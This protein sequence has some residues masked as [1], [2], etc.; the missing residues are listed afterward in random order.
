MLIVGAVAGVLASVLVVV[1]SGGVGA[2]GGVS[3]PSGL[4]AV[5]VEGGVL[6]SWDAPE[7]GASEVSGYRVFRRLPESGERRLSVL[8][9]DTGSSE[10]SFLDVSAVVEGELFV[11]RVAAL[12]D[13]VVGEGS[14]RARVRYEA[15]EPELEPV[16]RAVEPEPEVEADAD[17]VVLSG[18]LSVGSQGGVSPAMSGFSS[19]ARAGS[20]SPRSFTVDGSAVRVL[21]LVEH[22]GG[23]FLATDQAM[24][25]DFVL[26]V[27]GLEFVGSESLVPA[28]PVRGA[29]WWPSGGLS[30]SDGDTVDVEL[31]VAADAVPIG[32]RAAAPLWAYF[33][34]VP[35]THDGTDAFS[36][37]LRFGED[38][39][40]DA[41]ALRDSIVVAAGGTVTAVEPAAGSTRNWTVTI[42]PDGDS[43][44]TISVGG[45]L[46]CADLAAV[47]TA[48]GRTLPAGIEVTV[49]GPSAA[50]SLD[51]L[52][53]DGALLDQAFDPEVT[54]Y[55][56]QADVGISQVTVAGVAR[57]AA[58]SVDILPADADPNAA[59]HQIAVTEGA[60]TAVAVTVTAADRN[61]ERRYWVV[62]DGPPEAGGNDVQEVPGLTGLVLDGL[63][64]FGFTPAQRRYEAVKA[65]GVSMVTV[66][67]SSDDSD[68]TVEVLVVRSDDSPLVIDTNDA[69]PNTAGH[70]VALSEAGETLLLVLV[71]SADAKRQD[72]YLVLVR[73]PALQPPAA[74]GAPVTKNT[75]AP[76]LLRSTPGVALRDTAVP[77]LTALSLDGI[78]LSP[79]FAAA[80]TDYTATVDADTAQVTVTATPAGDA[81]V[82]FTPADADLNSAGWQVALPAAD[83]GG[84]PTQTNIAAIVVSGDTMA[85]NSYLITVT[86]QAPPADDASL[87]SLAL[88]GVA[89]SP[90][91]D[92]ATHSYTAEVGSDVDQVTLDLAA[93]AGATVTVVPADDDPNTA[94][95]QIPLADVQ[96]GGQ[97][98][99]TMVAIIV[100]AADTNTRQTYTVTVTRQAPSAPSPITAVLPE[101]CVLE[102]LNAKDDGTFR[103]SGVWRPECQSIFEYRTNSDDPVAATG[104]ARFYRLDVLGQG[105]VTIEVESDTSRHILLR[106]ADGTLV[107]HTTYLIVPPSDDSCVAL[108]GVSC[109]G[110]PVLNA[111]LPTGSYIVETVQHYR[112]GRQRRS[113][114]TVEGPNIYSV[115]PR[116]AALSVDGTSVA[117]FDYNTFVYELARQSATVTVAAEA[118]AAPPSSAA[119]S[120]LIE[121]ADADAD[122]AGHQVELAEYGLT[123]VTVT[124]TDG[125]G[126]GSNRYVVAF[127]GDHQATTSTSGSI[128]V[129]GSVRARVDSNGDRD[130]FAVDL[131]ADSTYRIDLKGKSS[132]SGSLVDPHMFGVRLADGT[133][134]AG[135]DDDNSGD[136]KNS[137]LWFV[138]SVTGTHFVDV[139]ADGSGTGIYELSVSG[140][141]DDFAAST[142]TVGAVAVDGTVVSGAVEFLG[143]RDWLAATLE[144]GRTYL[145]QL[146][147]SPS[148]VGTLADPHLFG[149]HDDAGVLVAGTSD[150]DSGAGAEAESVFAPTVDGEYFV[151]AGAGGNGTGSY[152]LSVFDVAD[153]FPGDLA[154]DSSTSGA[155]AVGGSTNGAVEFEGD[156]DWFA[157]SLEAGAEYLVSVSRRG[158]G[159]GSLADPRLVGIYGDDEVLIAGTSD[160]G[161]G[162]GSSSAVLFAA[163]S[164][165]TYYVAAGAA[166]DALGTYAVT[167]GAGF[168]ESVSEPSGGDVSAGVS[169]AGRLVSGGEVTGAVA[170]PGTDVD[171]FAVY[172]E[173]GEWYRIYAN[174]QRSAVS[175]LVRIP[176]IHDRDG[177][178]VPGSGA[179][180]GFWNESLEF[181]SPPYTGL[182]FVAVDT[183]WGSSGYASSPYTLSFKKISDVRSADTT[184]TGRVRVNG[185]VR[186]RVDYP[187]DR[188]WYRVNLAAGKVYTF[189]L[190][191]VT[192]DYGVYTTYGT[193][194][195]PVLHG[196][197][198]ADGV[199]ADGEILREWHST[200]IHDGG[201][202][203]YFVPEV[204]GAFY[205][206]A[207]TFPGSG[208]FDD[209]GTYTLRVNRMPDDHPADTSTTG[210]VTV[211]DKAGG[212]VQFPDDVDWF[213]VE[214]EA[215]KSYWVRAKGWRSGHGTLR[216]TKING[217]YDSGGVLIAG[218]TSDGGGVGDFNAT[219]VF[220]PEAAGTYYVSVSQHGWSWGD[221]WAGG[222]YK[223]F[224][225]DVTDGIP[226]DCGEDAASACAL[227]VPGG[228]RGNLE[229]DGDSDWFA[230][231]LSAGK[232]YKFD[233]DGV[234]FSFGPVTGVT[235][236]SPR[237][238]GVYDGD[239]IKLRGTSG[240]PVQFTPLVSGTYYVEAGAN[241]RDSNG[242]GTYWLSVRKTGSVPEPVDDYP[243]DDSTYGSLRAGGAATGVIDFR[244]DKDWFKAFLVADAV[245]TITLEGAGTDPLDDARVGGVY[246]IDGTLLSADAD[247]TGSVDVDSVMTF[248]ATSSGLHFI[249]AAGHV[250]ANG[251][252]TGSYRMT[253]D[254]DLEAG[255]PLTLG[256]SAAGEFTVADTESHLYSV[257]LEAG[258]DYWIQ[259]DPGSLDHPYLARVYDQDGV[260]VYDHSG[261]PSELAAR[262]RRIT[263]SKDGIYFVVVAATTSLTDADDDGIGTYRITVSDLSDTALTAVAG[264]AG[265]SALTVGVLQR[266]SIDAYQ[267]TDRYRVYLEGGV[268]YRIDMEGDWTGY[269]DANGDWVATATLYNP[270]IEAVYHEDDTAA[271]LIVGSGH[272]DAGIGQNSQVAF[273]PAADGFYLIDAA[274]EHAWTG[275]YVLTVVDANG[276]SADTNRLTQAAEAQAATAQAVTALA[277]G[278]SASGEITVADTEAHVYL[279]ELEA[280]VD[281]WVQADPGTLNHPYLLRIYD[282]DG[283][284]V[285]DHSGEP[286]ELGARLRRITVSND[287]AYFI[288]VAATTSLTDPDGIGTYRITVSDMSDTALT[289][290]AGQAG[291]SALVVGGV[292]RSSI[293]T[294][295]ETDRYR[296]YLEAGVEYRID[297]EGAWTGYRDANGSW[298]VTASLFNPIIEAV[299]HEDDTAADLIVGSGHHD[300]GVGQ[301]SRV[302]F[303]P[304]ADGFYLIDASA[305]Q[306][307]TGTYVLTVN[308]VS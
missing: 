142:A 225:D 64:S 305:E 144:A 103:K 95:W 264:Q 43:D 287:G 146:R 250:D 49:A 254:I 83:A 199:L 47:C 161:A 243:A 278:V 106:S 162:V 241:T 157:V 155:V 21:V 29:Y 266:S 115:T 101:G 22:A 151:A 8:V 105:R 239:G 138:A 290:V 68:A 2:A 279:V 9:S 152:E 139:G 303:T 125:D 56:A 299:Y 39:D 212:N 30:W 113:T 262:L 93:A 179:A 283:V 224:V 97:P 190:V 300:A 252:S 119:H 238:L 191:G 192:G 282:Q 245:Y 11:Y 174:A 185:S 172:M 206:S 15:P 150:A 137:A 75:V 135:T 6:L 175:W 25:S 72:I 87:N 92:P 128:N 126:V 218:T 244:G 272:H 60:Q 164:T 255:T 35:D 169:T 70:Q 133:L 14:V 124:V 165:G 220:T 251:W 67:A 12:F 258:E 20:L 173:A 168:A 277:V 181:F 69:D 66:I 63:A 302:V 306:A 268:E 219:L 110:N 55:T 1:P 17:V 203:V 4:S 223:L 187:T 222:T 221:G 28:L 233:S 248:T 204:S 41:A 131:V 267:E 231:E 136:G 16:L 50:V 294:N 130:W 53:L 186:G 77:T 189:E 120:V 158:N 178:K 10:T 160:D 247:Y 274:A 34:R 129:G 195:D 88:D 80:T 46:G 114:V 31:R 100:T 171:W 297:M 85:V 259:A 301:N 215:D 61:S 81:T 153:G 257:E 285:H 265:V 44:V 281:Y 256:E 194:E 293:D 217:V 148:G 145:F 166:G 280:D 65:A 230:V 163:D 193:L 132:A 197:Y 240:N 208:Y 308:A 51:A 90:A 24:G 236:Y 271:D 296:V 140:L 86:R 123:E 176:G 288:V 201:E 289:A 79:Q 13:G 235:L 52:S 298:I 275:T 269:R 32:V 7:S 177:Q 45:A 276:W 111:T 143:D 273:T 170:S 58:A 180:A 216:S 102:T 149:V 227:G 48:D 154:Q 147:G 36:V 94:G 260:A 37:R 121:P 253:L 270:I 295:Y 205:I 116:L 112:D 84:A 304:A 18:V 261:E 134:V 292:Q 107:K 167:L 202:R 184:T 118:T 109:S 23:V 82:M 307:W 198:D 33:D 188:D 108:F 210:S 127:S 54:L 104:N 249:E 62:V 284:V 38:V 214:L 183:Y 211:G 26:D 209:T 59:G 71:T 96:P 99:T 40:T 117:G 207:G 242:V 228:K 200:D 3:A 234:S 182:Y 229:V 122:T 246:D 78:T 73:Q 226:D 5:S 42:Q 156:V 91:F 232:S 27:G 213:A 141:A 263:A 57:D 159:G 74:P 237:I 286:S 291:V 196:V 19:W 89:L 98:S 76:G